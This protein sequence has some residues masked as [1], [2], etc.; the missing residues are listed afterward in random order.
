LHET[1]VADT[2]GEARCVEV[3][4]QRDDVLARRAEQI[5]DLGHRE[6]G[7]MRELRANS[8]PDIV[9]CVGMDEPAGLAVVGP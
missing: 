9:E 3:L 2:G 8:P 1:L 5:P 4:H 7:G 6:F